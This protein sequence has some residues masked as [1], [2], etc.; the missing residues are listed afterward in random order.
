MRIRLEHLTHV[1]GEKERREAD[2]TAFERFKTYEP[3]RC[4]RVGKDIRI[5]PYFVSHSA[6]DAYMF[7]V[8]ADG[9]RILHTGDFRQHGYLGKGL[10]PTLEKYIAPQGIDVLIT[11]GTIRKSSMRTT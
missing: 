4:I 11:E 1:P 7:L 5:T 9:K 6:A 2:L 3:A 8:E 10:L